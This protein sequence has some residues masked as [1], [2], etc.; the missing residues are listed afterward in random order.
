MDNKSWF[1]KRSETE[2]RRVTANTLYDLE[3]ECR[4]QGWGADP[5]RAFRPGVPALDGFPFGVW[6]LAGALE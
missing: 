4:R 2:M 1:T 6:R 5:A 3:M